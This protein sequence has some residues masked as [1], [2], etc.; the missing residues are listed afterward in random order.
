MKPFHAPQG[1]AEAK[2]ISRLHNTKVP[3][4]HP[5]QQHPPPCSTLAIETSHGGKHRLTCPGVCNLM[6]SACVLGAAISFAL[7]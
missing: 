6:N 1:A 3:A 7:E 4:T 2:N 5:Q